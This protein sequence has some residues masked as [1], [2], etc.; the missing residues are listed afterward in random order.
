ML[1][2][3]PSWRA[4]ISSTPAPTSACEILKLAVPKR[5]KHRRAPNATRSIAMALATVVLP[6]MGRPLLK[7]LTR[8]RRHVV[9]HAPLDQ[10]DGHIRDATDQRQ[11]QDRNEYHRGVRLTLAEAQQIAQSGVSAHQL[12]DHDADHRE[13]RANARSGKHGRQRVGEFDFPENAL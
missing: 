11:H 6:F 13:R 12:S 7:R 2:A 9:E 8:A 3:L 10:D 5:P 4:E 1:A